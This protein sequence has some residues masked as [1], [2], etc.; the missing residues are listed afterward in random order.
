MIMVLPIIT[1]TAITMTENNSENN[2]SGTDNYDKMTMT[3]TMIKMIITGSTFYTQSLQIAPRSMATTEN[4]HLHQKSC[5]SLA[6]Y[7]HGGWK[8]NTLILL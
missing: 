4:I 3:K 1:M 8:K 5:S 2:D 6:K 7:R